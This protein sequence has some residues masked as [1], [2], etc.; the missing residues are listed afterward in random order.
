MRVGFG[1]A[2]SDLRIT[3]SLVL[4]LVIYAF[5]GGYV[6]GS[7]G[8]GGGAI[9]NPLLLSIGIPPAVASATGMYMI[10]FSTAG[11]STIYIIYRILNL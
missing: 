4:K 11:S 10:M 3:Q 7:L 6:S 9:F 2:P 1:L 8:L 5:I